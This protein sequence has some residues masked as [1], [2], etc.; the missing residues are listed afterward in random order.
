MQGEEESL[1]CLLPR[2]PDLLQHS[3]AAS[4]PPAPHVPHAAGQLAGAGP[5]GKLC[6]QARGVTGKREA[7]ALF[8]GKAHSPAAVDRPRCSPT[9]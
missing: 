1:D 8:S 6:A 4:A 7:A 2:D 3:A 9:T 5:A